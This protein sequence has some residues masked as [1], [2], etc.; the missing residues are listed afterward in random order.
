MGKPLGE[1]DPRE[2]QFALRKVTEALATELAC[3]TPQ[4]PNWSEFEWIVARAVAAM[5]GVSPLLSRALRWQG[6]PGWKQFLEQQRAHTAA[7]HSRIHELLGRIDGAAKDSGVAAVALKGVALHAMGVYSVGDRPMADIDL[8]VRP[9]DV[10]RSVGMLQSLGF[11][12]SLET[13]K[14][15]VFSPI[16][17]RQSADLGEH[18]NNIIK[19]ELHERICERLPWRITD[20]TD[21]VFPAHVNPGLNGYSSKASLMTHLLLHAAGTMPTRTLRLLHLHDLAQLASRMT[22]IDWGEVLAPGERGRPLWWASPPLELT[23]RYFP[24]AIA[25]QVLA[26]FADQCPWLLTCVSRRRTLY[27]VSFSYPWIDAFPGVEWSQ[28]L[29]EALQYA[30]SRL[31]PS[32]EHKAQR[33]YVARAEAWVKGSQWPHLSQSR[34][35]LR[36]VTSHPTRPL[37]AHAVNAAI[38]QAQ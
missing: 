24:K 27:D 8:L 11:R 13:W 28:S 14:E 26:S 17:D 33:K 16:D 10:Q 35:V 22:T 4:G 5:H 19:V 2:L 9:A 36:W 21:V 18:E 3:P 20:A 12:Q 34:R 38:A 15:R 29:P 6:P 37:T 23:A 25:P 30:A 1:L 31:R 7:R 32:A